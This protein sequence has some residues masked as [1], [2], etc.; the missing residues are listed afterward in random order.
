MPDAPNPA[1]AATLRGLSQASSADALHALCSRIYEQLLE[2]VTSAN[3]AQSRHLMTSDLDA[4][5]YEAPKIFVPRDGRA[6]RDGSIARL[7]REAA[8][9][10]VG[11]FLSSEQVSPTLSSPTLP[12]PIP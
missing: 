1:Q 10:S 6:P 3:E 12:Y 5:F 2:R 9:P 7:V 4:D 8:L 11:R